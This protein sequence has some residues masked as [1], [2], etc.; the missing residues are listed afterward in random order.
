M[1]VEIEKMR[2]EISKLLA[3]VYKTNRENHWIP[4][5]YGAALFGAACA[6]VIGIATVV[7][8]FLH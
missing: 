6:L 1:E 3:D 2:V 8:L 5:T 7:K 4:V